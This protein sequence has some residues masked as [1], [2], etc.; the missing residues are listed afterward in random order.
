[1]PR[2]DSDPQRTADHPVKPHVV[3]RHDAK[4][5]RLVQRMSPDGEF[6]QYEW[7]RL[8]RSPRIINELV[9]GF[10]STVVPNWS[11]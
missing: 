4:A 9:V 1:M 10:S 2:W 5:A 8:R 7:R 3:S 6:R 11:H